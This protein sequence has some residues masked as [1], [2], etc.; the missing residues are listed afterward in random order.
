MLY[1]GTS[2]CSPNICYQIEY[3]YKNCKIIKILHKKVVP[4]N[5][6]ISL[7]V[8]EGVSY[9]L[10]YETYFCCLHSLISV[11]ILSVIMRYLFLKL[12]LC[13]SL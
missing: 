7:I 6:I 2:T 11:L 4:H 10:S 8:R 12:S 3:K 9:S 1:I 5:S 13:F